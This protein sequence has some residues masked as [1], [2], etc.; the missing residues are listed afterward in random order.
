MIIE[1]FDLVQVSVEAADE[2]KAMD[3]TVL[4][5]GEVSIVAEY[6]VICSSRSPVH[7]RAIA[8][9]VEERLKQHD[10][11]RPCIEGFRTGRW[12]LLDYGSVIIHIFQE[13]ERRFYNLEHLWGDAQVVKSQ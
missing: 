12:V 13:E 3:I 6:F 1:P 2:K 5:I 11:D 9:E 8:E 7:A 10:V 4:N